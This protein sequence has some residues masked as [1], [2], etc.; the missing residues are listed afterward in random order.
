VAGA[1]VVPVVAD[2][3]P[4]L[5]PRTTAE[6]LAA[7]GGS[8]AVPLSGTVVETARL[9]FPALPDTGSSLSPAALVTGSHTLRVWY[10][11]G[12][13][14][15]LALVGT[16]A[17]TDLVRNGQDAWLWTSGA[18]TAQHVT[19]PAHDATEKVPA[20]TS[21]A[22]LT[23]Q[24]AASKALAAVD[25]ST[26]VSLGP[27]TKVAGRSAYQLVLQPRDARS[28][29]GSVRI[30][31]DA[32]TSVPLGVSVWASGS[33]GRPAFETAFSSVSFSKP[34]ASVFRFSPPAG[35]KVSELGD[36]AGR[37]AGAAESGAAKSGTAKSGAAKPGSAAASEQGP[38]VIGS[39]WTAVVALTGVDLPTAPTRARGDHRDRAT[40]T[41]QLAAITKAMTPVSGAF[42]TG[43]LLRTALVSVLVLDDGRTFV[44]AVP[45]AVL[46]AAATA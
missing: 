46:E 25:P 14:A 17:E 36:L 42:G 31:V 43:H 5:A 37:R 9:G 30:A 16:L 39:G 40:A 8:G 26:K 18:N 32:D 2:A 7:V 45:P 33:P 34:S 24:E 4:R 21:A 44:G 27:T 38:R 10:D 6:L 11:G 22:G 13:R 3:S 1:L 12:D 15:R 28:L 41:D 35:A 29:V 20:P 19:L 23:P